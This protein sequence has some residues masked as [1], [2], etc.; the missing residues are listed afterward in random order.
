MKITMSRG[1]GEIGEAVFLPVHAQQRKIR[2]LVPE[3]KGVGV[4]RQ[5]V[6][7]QGVG[8]EGRRFSRGE[9]KQGAEGDSGKAEKVFHFRREE[10]GFM[11]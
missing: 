5:S 11:A 2:G 8:G 1:G 4:R 9:R 7:E 3:L 10:R 6:L